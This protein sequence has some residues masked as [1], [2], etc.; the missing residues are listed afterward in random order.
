MNKA[1][2]FTSI[3]IALK[4][5][6][7]GHW[8]QKRDSSEQ[9]IFNEIDFARWLEAHGETGPSDTRFI[10]ERANIVCQLIDISNAKTDEQVYIKLFSARRYRQRS[11]IT[12]SQFKR[13]AIL[14]HYYLKSRTHTSQLEPLARIN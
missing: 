2:L 11:Q 6:R 12:R 4:S 1:S 3:A 8:A 7:F 9:S 14:L 5:A 10:I 13:T